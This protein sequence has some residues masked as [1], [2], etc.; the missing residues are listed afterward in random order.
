[1]MQQTWLFLGAFAAIASGLGFIAEQPDRGVL[2]GLIGFF[3][4]AI[5][6]YGAFRVQI[7][8]QGGGQPIELQYPVLALFGGALAVFALAVT[9]DSVLSLLNP[10]ESEELLKDWGRGQDGRRY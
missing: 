9:I 6:S 1:M 7:T 10:E 2:G 4:W 5:W 3:A 8:D